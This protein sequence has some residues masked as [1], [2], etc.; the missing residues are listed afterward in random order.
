MN[1]NIGSFAELK[2]VFKDY[3]AW[4]MLSSLDVKNCDPDFIRSADKIK[5]YAVQLC[6]LIKM[7]RFGDCQVV[8]FGES[9]VVA[10]FS[11]IQ[12]IETSCISGH[13]ANATNHAYIDIFSCKEY[14]PYE[15]ALFTQQFFKAE[16]YEINVL[17]RK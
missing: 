4:G 3:H 14:D 2:K 17:L 13:F 5:E 8:H 9:E 15:A 12:L 7:K 10:G 6:D 1:I 11:M 16:K